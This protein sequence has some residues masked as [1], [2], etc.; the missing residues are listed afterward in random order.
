MDSKPKGASAGTLIA[1]PATEAQNGFGRLVD[2]AAAGQ[3]I[4]ITRHNVERA[5][6]VSASRYHQL[7]AGIAARQAAALAALSAQMDELYD[8][9]QTPEVRAANRRAL[10]MT[11]EQMGRAA[12]AAARKAAGD[13]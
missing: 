6:L 5:V 4:A 8:E 11:P 3:D 9:M 12:V 13:L 7:V 2:Q 10:Q 1:V